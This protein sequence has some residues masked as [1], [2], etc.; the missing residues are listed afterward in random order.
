MTGAKQPIT[1]TFYNVDISEDMPFTDPVAKKITE[2]TGVTLLVD[3][4]LA[5]DQQ[6]IP[7]M[8]ASLSLLGVMMIHVRPLSATAWKTEPMPIFRLWLMRVMFARL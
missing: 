3:H 4:P 2:R 8:I 1:F 7:L 6:A 5:E